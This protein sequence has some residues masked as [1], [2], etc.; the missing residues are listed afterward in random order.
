MKKQVDIVV[1]TNWSAVTL[2]KYLELRT[3]MKN[4][5]DDNDAVI[6]CLFH[7]LCGFPVEYISKLP[8]DTYTQIVSDLTNFL[9]KIDYPLQQL[10]TIDGVEY[11]FEPDLSKMSY[12][13]YVDITK[14][15]SINVDDTWAE[16]MSI[17]YRPVTKKVGKLYDIQPYS[18]N[19]DK[20][21]FLN[22]SMD[23]HF[24]AVFF[25][26]S[27]LMDL[28]SDTLNSLTDLKEMYPSIN[29]TLQRSGKL[30][31]QLSNLQMGISKESMK[32]PKNL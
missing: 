22:V 28:S 12:G 9:N 3:D 25:F 15:E 1:P 23:A 2:K 26:K 27:L 20:E 24:G 4:Y 13:A 14:Y 17:L 11:G 31:H 5:D 21:K 29:T 32:L 30:I 19:I 7:H 16:I 8:N 18:G 6:A 10:I